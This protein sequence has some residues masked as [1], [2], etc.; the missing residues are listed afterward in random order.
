VNQFSI[1]VVDNSA[2]ELMIVKRIIKKSR[3]D[4]VVETAMDGAEVI[5]QLQNIT[6]LSMILLDLKLPGM[7]GIDILRFI[8]THD[9]TKYTPVII[10][11]SSTLDSDVRAVYDAGASGFIHK[12]HDLDLY[13]E[14]IT[15]T[16]Q[17]WIN[18]NISPDN[19]CCG[20]LES[21][22]GKSS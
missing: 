15:K 1:L 11:T 10:M 20:N 13:A 3:P 14:N 5:L 16:I 21:K 9:T 12:L 17:F 7:N 6:H 8:R 2:E 22:A 19:T 18:I 4:C